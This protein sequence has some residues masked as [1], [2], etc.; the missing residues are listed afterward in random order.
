MQ[1]L[2]LVL[3][4]TVMVSIGA[5]LKLYKFQ[6]YTARQTLYYAV[7]MSV[8]FSTVFFAREYLSTKGFNIH[9]V[10]YFIVILVPVAIF[11]VKFEPKQ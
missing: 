4:L 3:I 7:V 2:L 6:G 5:Y 10:V 11:A 1:N 8:A 9:Y